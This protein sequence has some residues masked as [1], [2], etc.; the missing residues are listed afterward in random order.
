M[1]QAHLKFHL[2][3]LEVIKVPL[4]HMWLLNTNILFI[5]I[6][7]IRNK[8]SVGALETQSAIA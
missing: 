8:P 2:R 4:V 6:V 3:L 7:P 1:K 5:Y